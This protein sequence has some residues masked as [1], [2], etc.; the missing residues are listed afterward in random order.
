MT[1]EPTPGYSRDKELENIMGNL[2]ITMFQQD[3]LEERLIAKLSSFGSDGP[4]THATDV[5]G[6]SVVFRC[7]GKLYRMTFIAES[8]AVNE[9][10]EEDSSATSTEIGC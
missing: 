5:K 10:K 2:A 1:Q 7:G 4:G 6:S 8:M 3:R 9:A